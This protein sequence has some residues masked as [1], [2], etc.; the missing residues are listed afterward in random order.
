[1]NFSELHPLSLIM[2]FASVIA[3]TMAT[4]NPV[5]LLLSFLC[6]FF[7][8]ALL[9]CGKELWWPLVLL[10]AVSITNPLFSHNGVTVLFY[11]FGQQI[12]LEAF[13]YGL[14]AGVRIVS[15]IYW[16]ALFGAFFKQDKLNWLFG[17]MSPKLSI[18]FSMALRFIPLVR[19]NATD[20]YNAQRTMCTFDTTKL[21]GKIKLISNTLSAL[22]SLSI[23]NAIETAD[24]MRSRGF[25][26]KNRTAFSLFRFKKKDIF[27]ILSVLFIDLC[28][29]YFLLSGIGAF[30][31][32][33]EIRFA[34]WINSNIAFYFL[35]TLLCAMPMI[36]DLTE[37][38]RWK[39]SISKI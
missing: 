35:Y 13:I 28:T 20:I 15:V 34:F 39:Y 17:K 24:T 5:L 7:S 22:V 16:F 10:A 37:N 31:Y 8:N 11:L 14:M 29:I 32:Y 3:F 1:M 33:P 26:N 27:I 2:F 38:L 19:K 23:E 25:E 18:V 12:T 6:A 36:N 30:Y 9:K 21:A 4:M